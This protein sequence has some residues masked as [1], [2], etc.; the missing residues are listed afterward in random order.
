MAIT[1]AP[2]TQRAPRYDEE[3]TSFTTGKELR[4]WYSYGLAAETFAVCGI[5]TDRH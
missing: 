2:R 3:D 5:G 1:G 4:G